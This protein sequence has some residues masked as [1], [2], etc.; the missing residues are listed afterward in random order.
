MSASE[1]HSLLACV[2]KLG[3]ARVL[4][5]GDLMLDRYMYGEVTR[6]SP[7][8]PVPVLRV[9]R[10]QAMPGG[11][12]NAVRN[13]A[14]LGATV[15][16]LSAIGTDSAANEIVELLRQNPSCTV[17]VEREPGRTTPVKT[18]FIAHNQQLLR[19]DAETSHPLRGD[20]REAL[21][22]R[23]EEALD[24]SGVVLLSDYAKGVL[25]GTYATEL[26]VLA[27]ARGVPVVVDPKGR[28]FRR[29]EGAMLVKPNLK[30]LAEAS[31]LPVS[32]DEEVEAAG[33]S[34]LEDIAMGG[35]LVTRGAAGMMLIPRAG[36][37]VR[38]PALAREVYDV[39]GAGDTVA[40]ALAAGIGAGLSIEEA[41]QISNV[42]AGIVVG[43]AGTAVVSRAEII[44][45][46]QQRSLIDA[47]SKVL[48]MSDAAERVRRWQSAGL[49]VGFAS[50]SFDL[51]HPGHIASLEQARAG[52][53]R[54][55][56][57]LHGDA[58]AER[59]NGPA[60]FVQDEVARSIVLAS[61]QCVDLVV[62]LEDSTHWGLVCA[63]QPDA[64]LNENHQPANSRR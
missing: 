38:F 41:A 13:L 45:E 52:C 22:R 63:L 2:E 53:D 7:E 46:L 24:S 54:L 50:G 16:V 29:Y 62:V 10:E 3:N 30:E 15:T 19:A 43:K 12:G 55:V 44:Q 32:T 6:I 56:I 58:V 35:L 33:R 61:L 11:S 25:S 20:T 18:R 57:G 23:F 4:C 28:D 42:A 40:A 31:G 51:L 14:T 21:K 8:G 59:R 64:V 26:I 9:E 17:L 39:S 49:R 36:D 47:R 27:A 37:V 1:I 48:R 5:A 60:G 34:L